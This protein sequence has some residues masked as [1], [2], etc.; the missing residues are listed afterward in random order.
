[1]YQLVCFPKYS[2]GGVG[3]VFYFSNPLRLTAALPTCDVK[4]LWIFL[5]KIYRLA[6]KGTKVFGA[7]EPS[8]STLSLSRVL[9]RCSHKSEVYQSCAL[10]FFV[11]LCISLDLV[12]V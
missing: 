4:H 5:F 10:H 9:R 8:L 7:V 1:M 6:S 3:E 12:I 2:L 11:Q